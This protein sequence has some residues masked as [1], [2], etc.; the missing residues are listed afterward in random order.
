MRW[1][2][3]KACCSALLIGA[4]GYAFFLVDDY[5]QRMAEVLR[6]LPL[7]TALDDR[8][9]FV[10]AFVFAYALYYVWLLLPLPILTRRDDFYRALGAFALV[11]LVALCVFLALPSR[12]VRPEFVPVGAAGYFLHQIYQVDQ[13]WN[14]FPSLHVA[15]STLVALLYFR[16]RREFFPPVAFGAG[17][18]ALSTVMVKQH[19][20]L[21]L[22]A[23]VL[24]AAVA[25]VTTVR[26]PSP[27]SFAGRQSSRP[28]RATPSV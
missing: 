11:E 22:P 16:H 18:I 8:I 1:S 7:A 13:G 19:Y 4:G 14:V 3:E 24:L 17:L 10:P 12:M 28:A 27:V 2:T 6:P 21:D 15:H 26:G 5:N 9:P 20:L 23:G 25:F